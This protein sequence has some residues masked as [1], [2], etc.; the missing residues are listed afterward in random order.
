MVRK[1]V[2]HVEDALTNLSSPRRPARL[3]RQLALALALASGTALIAVPGLADAAHAQK[4]KKD[5]KEAA[6]PVYTEAF[7]KGYQPLDAAMKAPAPDVTALK[8]QMVALQSLATSPDEKLAL[9]A[10]MFNGGIIGKD[11][12]LQLQGVELMLGS[13]KATGDDAGRY[14]VVASQLAGSLKDYDKARS[15]LQKAIDLNYSGP[16]I[17]AADLRL[18]MAE[19]YFSENRDAEG[20]KYLGDAIAA[21]R[22]QGTKVD[23]RWY[24]RGISVAYAGEI[25]PQVYDFVE[26]W[27]SDYPTTENWRDAINL[28]R[29]LNDFEAP[30]MLDLLRLG[31]RVDTLNAKNDYV[32]YIEA[33]DTRRLPAE[34]KRVIDEA[35]ARGVI[36]KGSDSWVEEQYKL[37]SNTVGE[38]R[39]AL[40]VLERDANAASAQLRTVMA[41]GEAF[42]SHDD[43][44]KAVAF[45]ER[46]LGMPGADRN[47]VLT[48]L[49]IAQIGAG[50]AGAARENLA[51]I[52]GARVPVARLWSA[53]AAQK[54]APATGG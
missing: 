19:L 7:V 45:Y 26:G 33:A 31:D 16:N 27:V 53:Y 4:K 30:V 20:L 12:S 21:Q 22:A 38:D 51:K 5:E 1:A 8:P 10:M 15:Y 6:K 14:N 49:A 23:E 34:V 40:P 47:M 18:S 13:G 46:A 2:L 42:L 11:P 32:Y 29:N 17:A 43:F 36:P 9:G 54:A 24:R 41:A 3:G 52:E 39:T 48:R 37:A 25:V 50:N 35:Y 28:T 44:A